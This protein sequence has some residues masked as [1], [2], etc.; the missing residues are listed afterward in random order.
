MNHLYQKTRMPR[1]SLSIPT[2]FLVAPD[3]LH[4]KRHKHGIL[5]LAITVAG[6]VGKTKQYLFNNY[7]L[8][9]DNGSFERSSNLSHCVYFACSI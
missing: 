9:K 8:N 5:Y 4:I 3:K 6:G 1:R 7:V 2:R